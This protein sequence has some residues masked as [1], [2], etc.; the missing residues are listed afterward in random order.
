MNK[1]LRENSVVIGYVSFMGVRIIFSFFIVS[2][3]ALGFP[4]ASYM[5]LGMRM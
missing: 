1:C 5:C 2:W 4:S 3:K